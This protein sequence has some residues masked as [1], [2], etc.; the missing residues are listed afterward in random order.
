MTTVTVPIKHFIYIY[1]FLTVILMSPTNGL[2][3]TEREQTLSMQKT[4]SHGTI[5]FDFESDKEINYWHDEG[6]TIISGKTLRRVKRFATSGDYSMEF[7]TPKWKKGMPEWPAFECVP[8]ITDWS[9]ADR[10]VFDVTNASSD[11]QVLMMFISDSHTK[12]RK[13]LHHRIALRPLSYTRVVVDIANGFKAKKIDAS[14]IHVIHFFTARPP[15]DLCVYIDRM[16]LLRKGEKLPFPA[17]GYKH[18]FLELQGNALNQLRIKLDETQ[19]WLDSAVKTITC[20]RWIMKNLITW[21][22][23]GIDLYERASAEKLSVRS[24]INLPDTINEIISSINRVEDIGKLWSQFDAVASSS[25]LEKAGRKDVVAGFATSMEKILP[26]TG[27]V[28]NQVRIS[29]QIK[30]SLAKREKEAFQVIVI[31]YK[32]DLKKVAIKIGNLISDN[33]AVFKAENIR[34]VPVGY[35]RT[36]SIPPYGSSHV[37]WWPDPILDFM[38]T[39]EISKG[40][41]QAFWIRITA[42]K[43][44]LS[45]IYRGTLTIC[46]KGQPLLKFELSVRVYDFDV[47]TDSPLPLAIT[48]FPHDCPTQETKAEQYEWRKQPDYP[49]NIW[50]RHKQ[51][52]AEFLA[53]YYI[54]FDSLYEYSGWSPDF[55]ILSRLKKQ[56]RL[57]RFNL[58][59]FGPCPKETSAQK[60]WREKTIDKILPRYQKAKKL[61]LIKHAYIYGCDECPSSKFGDVERA[62]A[63]LK[64]AFPDVMIMTTT[65]DKSYSL[66]TKVKSIDAWCPLTP[67][68]NMSKASRARAAGKQVWWYICCSPHHPYPNMFIE[69]PAIEGRLLM[70]AMT[71]K[72]RPDG[73]LYYQISIWNSRTPILKGPFTDWDPRSWTNYHG[74]GAWTCVGPDGIPLATIRLENFRDGLEDYAY[75]LKLHTMIK[76]IEN[77]YSFI[78]AATKA[79]L[80]EAKLALIVPSS[81]V[82][83]LTSYS[84]NPQKLYMWR[85]RIADIIEKLNRSEELCNSDCNHD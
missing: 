45:G 77:N 59:Y 1:V 8:P 53:E 71:A 36:K 12:T 33:G 32:S 64:K 76:N 65:Y 79:L 83:S 17:E 70:G 60:A 74:D 19:R 38:K 66:K 40:D 5:I 85:N 67:N 26:K 49:L 75:V 52:W 55:N 44:Q 13:G 68:F 42:P 20:P 6:T 27:L 37:G 22:A 54:T 4:N 16:I 25:R 41:A 2:S 31:P 51:Q 46:E 69:Y 82:D 14:D 58:G 62:A 80:K 7:A 72:Y 63:M 47:P 24:V 84:H 28:S 35:V 61:G 39:T 57:G 81:L 21:R 50:K 29:K 11:W 18:D 3:L 15:A 43:N 78:S 30:V 48:F 23:K 56:G 34:A 9:G 10:L 73:F